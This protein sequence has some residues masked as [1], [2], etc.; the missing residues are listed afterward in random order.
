MGKAD[1]F[2]LGTY[3][4]I[5]DTCGL[6]FKANQLRFTWDGYYVCAKCWEPRHPQDLVRG[7]Y[8][9]MTVPIARPD[10]DI[11]FYE[12][13]LN[14]NESAGDTSI[15]VVSMASMQ[16][17]SALMIQLDPMMGQTSQYHACTITTTPVVSTNILITPA[18]PW[19]ASS[20]NTVYVLDHGDYLTATEVTTDDL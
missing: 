17:Y 10:D 2:V 14:A 18:L 12:T 8:D 20:G 13:T 5:C 3:N 7:K 1:K 11:K 16:K 4:V 6:K 19:A 15:N 9:K